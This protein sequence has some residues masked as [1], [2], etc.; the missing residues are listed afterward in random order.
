MKQPVTRRQF[1]VSGALATGAL[2]LG[3]CATPWRSGRVPRCSAPTEKLN[4][5]IIGCGGKGW[6]DLEGVAGENIV[7][8]CDV[9]ENSLNRAAQKH[10]VAKLYRDYRKM[11]D[12][13]KTLD[14]VT[15]S[16]PDHH[17]YPAAVRA[18]T[19]SFR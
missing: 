8:L 17:H 15:I 18:I 6:T 13:L 1:L 10:P 2:A 12:E 11:L 7:A 19:R 16:T 14:A 4:I 3:G 9:D 5:G